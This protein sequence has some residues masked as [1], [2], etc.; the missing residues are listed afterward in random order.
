M[1]GNIQ[2]SMASANGVVPEVFSLTFNVS[3]GPPSYINCSVNGVM[4]HVPE[5]QIVRKVIDPIVPILTC[6]TVIFQT[7][8][9]GQYNCT[10]SN[11][12]VDKGTIGGVTAVAGSFQQEIKG[13]YIYISMFK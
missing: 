7:G 8:K 12:R 1:Q 2:F 11:S 3:D 9:E 5:E 13:I 10:V 6:V 4:I